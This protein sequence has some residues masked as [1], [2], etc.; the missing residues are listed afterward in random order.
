[1]FSRGFTTLVSYTW[2]KFLVRDSFLNEVDT[3]FERR[4]SDADIPHRIVVSGIYE[5]PF[6]RGRKWGKDLHRAVD[7]ILGGWQV[8]G[9]WQAQQGRPL[10]IGN[11][12]YNGDI[13]KLK[14]TVNSSRV[15]STVFDISGFYFT[16]AAVQTNGVVDPNKQRND[17]RIQLSGNYRTLPSRFAG[18]RG[19]GLNMAD[20]SVSKNFVITE[21]IKLQLRGEFLNA[22][23]T[24]FFDN[25]NLTPNNANF[26]R[27]TSQNNLP[28]DVQIG[29]RLVF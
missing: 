12:Y 6:G 27:V 7:T 3:Q 24:P 25:P 17:P 16:D 19:T 11:V 10:T 22:T 9:I 8:Q 21:T 5:L 18:F 2:S 1:R 28:R 23:N 13:T 14:T 4:L 20:L 15:D 29:L 26:G